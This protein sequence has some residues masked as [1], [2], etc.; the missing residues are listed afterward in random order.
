LLDI[1]GV[2]ADFIS[3]ALKYLEPIR[4]NIKHDDIT[5]Y[6]MEIPLGLTEAQTALWHQAIC[7]RGYCASIPAYDGAKEG[8]ARLKELGDVHPVTFP[9]PGSPWWFLE[10]ETWLQEHLGIDPGLAVYTKAK[11]LIAGDVFIE[12]TTSYL[13]EWR[14]HNP[15]GVAIRMARAYNVHEPFEQGI[16]V[17]NWSELVSEVQTALD[18][19]ERARRWVYAD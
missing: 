13:I 5:A 4:P 12:D 16:T 11:H 18:L 15:D 9:F 19:R 1:D 6:R 10:R 7:E 17:G 8:V 14:K 2:A 3:R